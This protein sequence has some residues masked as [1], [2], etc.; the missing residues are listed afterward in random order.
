MS[1]RILPKLEI[2]VRNS[3]HSPFQYPSDEEIFLYDGNRFRKQFSLYKP[4][5]KVWNKETATSRT[6]LT[7]FE[8]NCFFIKESLNSL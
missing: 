4:G 8:V 2:S 1:S 6:Q 3:S 7:R 5:S